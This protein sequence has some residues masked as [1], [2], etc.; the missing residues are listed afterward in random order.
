[1]GRLGS[2]ARAAARS[3]LSSH[4]LALLERAVSRP[5]HLLP[6]LAYHRIADPAALPLYPGLV[7]ATPD[8][9]R[10]QVR[11]IAERFNVVSLRE[12]L[13]VKLEQ[14]PLPER[15]LLLTFD[16]AYRDFAEH[17]WPA[18][19]EANLPATLFVPTAY[20]GEPERRFWWDRLH[21]ALALARRDVLA[22]PLGALPL[23]TP[24]ERTAAYRALRAHCKRLPHEEALAL[25]DGIATQLGEPPLPRLVLS[26][27]ELRAL[28]RAGVTL[29]PHTRTHPLLDRV[30]PAQARAEVE[31]SLADLERELGSVVRAF[32]YP[33]GA[34]S[35]AV[36]GVLAA[37]GIHAA[38]TIMRLGVNDLRRADWL[39]LRRINVT[40]TLGLPLLRAAT[41]PL[42]ARRTLG[43][44]ASDAP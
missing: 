31:G 39:R 21:A 30:P 5:G 27:D 15:A 37:A 29:A 10:A 22:S 2:L 43:A 41:L 8:E 11:W 18:L 14:R 36:L 40:R 28:A 12:V 20:P 42:G 44:S 3:A 16:D 7:S 25:V 32:A 24:G 26:W 17:A 33:S 38:F 13:A 6:V 1:M 19:R 4:V 34:F 35:P 9:F 23:T